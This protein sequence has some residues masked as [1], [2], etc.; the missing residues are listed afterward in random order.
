ML[1]ALT[2]LPSPA[3][4]NCELTFVAREPID[5]ALA[6]R[7]HEAYRGA[8]QASGARVIA[9]PPEPSFPDSVFVE[10]TAVILDE[11][12][13][14]TRSG[15]VSRRPEADLIEQEL[16]RFHRIVRLASPATLEGGDV[17]KIGKQLYVGIS[18]RTNAAG[19]EQLGRIVA[20]YGY[21]VIPVPVTGCLHLKTAIT[22][23]DDHT[24]LANPNWVD[25][26]PITSYDIISVPP[27]EPWGANVLRIQ[28]TLMLNAAFPKTRGIVEQRGYRV[29]AVDL[30]EFVKAEAGVTCLS[31]ILG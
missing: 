13:I 15:V 26:S 18:T 21:T 27:D 9:L 4:A 12:A 20:P 24:V 29:L 6:E 16:A 10:D 22:A 7:Q 23:L 25:L 1:T 30:S 14:I 31:L 11:V 19:M 5:F 8:L 3:L 28:D 2:R 17:L